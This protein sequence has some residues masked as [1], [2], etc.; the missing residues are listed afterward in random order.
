MKRK[1][2]ILNHSSKVLQRDPELQGMINIED[3]GERKEDGRDS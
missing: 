3:D 1:L 2:E